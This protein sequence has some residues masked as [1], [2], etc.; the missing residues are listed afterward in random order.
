MEW[1]EIYG[2]PRYLCCSSSSFLCTPVFLLITCT[3]V[4]SDLASVPEIESLHSVEA[5]VHRHNCSEPT[6]TFVRW[7]DVRTYLN[8]NHKANLP[9]D[10]DGP[11]LPV[12][13]CV[14]ELTPCVS[15]NSYCSVTTQE[16][17][18]RKLPLYVDTKPLDR[19]LL[20]LYVEDLK[21]ECVD[22]KTHDASFIPLGSVP[23]IL[24]LK[25]QNIN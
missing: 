8:D 9:S 21:C 3:L 24:D 14:N 23:F 6:V 13:R 2:N 1:N 25:L 19:S 17:S 15:H 20:I 12:K 18:V 7:H 22:K 4:S 11:P 5:L 16:Y 10:I